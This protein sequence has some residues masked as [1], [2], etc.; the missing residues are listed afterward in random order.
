MPLCIKLLNA[1]GLVYVE[2]GSP[3]PFAGAG[4]GDTPDWLAPWEAIR[5]D[6][7]GIVF[8]HLLKLRAAAAV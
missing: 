2:S 6:K 7:A 5:A 1:D 8:Y 4:E 3:L